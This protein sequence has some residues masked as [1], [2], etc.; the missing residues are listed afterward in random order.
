MLRHITLVVALLVAVPTS[1][2]D[3]PADVCATLRT[4]R[5]SA[6]IESNAQLGAM[7]NRVAWTH[8]AQ[9][10]GLSRKTAGNFCPSPAGLIACDILELPTG[11]AWD[12]FVGAEVGF[13]AAPNCGASFGVLND[14][15]RPWVAPVNP[16][17][18]VDPPPPPPPPPPLPAGDASTASLQQQQLVVLLQI[19]QQLERQNA[20]LLQQTETL[21][22]AIAELRAAI[23]AGV[24]IRF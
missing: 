15:S 12:V 4:E 6:P 8:R 10:L 22:R 11:V 19:V 5:G 14:P 16:G 18:V 24:K 21:G 20:A 13:P 23:A 2:Q 7:L 17:D 3:L 1:A 9:G